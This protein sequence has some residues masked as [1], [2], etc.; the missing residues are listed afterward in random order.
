MENLNLQKYE[1][2]LDMAQ[3]TRDIGK[4]TQVTGFLISGFIT[5]V[6]VGTV[7]EIFPN[8]GAPSFL[9]EVVGFKDREVLLMPLGEMRGLGLGSTILVRRNMASIPVG[10]ALLG[11]LINGMGQAIDGKGDLFLTE[12]VPL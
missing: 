11:R 12:E 5:E 9:S 7:C 8:S 6:S 1:R 2:A 4:V 10:D 3:L